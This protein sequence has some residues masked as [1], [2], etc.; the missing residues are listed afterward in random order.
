MK[1]RD[2]IVL[3]LCLISLLFFGI[4]EYGRS[5]L[6]AEAERWALEAKFKDCVLADEEGDHEVYLCRRPRE[7]FV[8]RRKST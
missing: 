4:A 3:V 6:E 1:M 2:A 5:S 7:E 8:F